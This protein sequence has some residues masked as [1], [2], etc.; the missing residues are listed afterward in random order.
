MQLPC[1]LTVLP[2][3]PR[4]LAPGCKKTNPLDTIAFFIDGATRMTESGAICH[5]LATRPG[6]SPLDVGQDEGDCAAF[7]DWSCFSDA[8]LTFPQTLVLRCSHLEPQV[9]EDHAKWFL[10]RLHAVEDAL[11]GRRWL[12]A[13]RFTVADFT[14]GHAPL[15]ARSG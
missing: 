5:C 9:A 8:T 6:P 4:V 12:C 10:G 1:E 11:E 7:L 3:T 13:G 14:I 15:L 2:F